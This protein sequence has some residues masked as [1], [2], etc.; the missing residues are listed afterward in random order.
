MAIDTLLEK[1]LHKSD[2]Q[3]DLFK[4]RDQRSSIAAYQT[5]SK[6][7]APSRIM[8]CVSPVHEGKGYKI[9]METR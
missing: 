1:E 2:I 5:S 8:G 3:S 6:S 4:C 9:E 7:N